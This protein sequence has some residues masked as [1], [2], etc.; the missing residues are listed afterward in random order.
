MFGRVETDFSGRTL[1]IESGKLAKQANGAAIVML[2]DE[3][4][5][6]QQGETGEVKA[7]AE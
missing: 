7:P 6:T 1:S 4:D 5:L 2:G 3:S